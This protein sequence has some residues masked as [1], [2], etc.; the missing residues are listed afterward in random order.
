[1]GNFTSVLLHEHLQPLLTVSYFLPDLIF[2]I[3]S[4][5]EKVD[6]PNKEGGQ[7]TDST[8]KSD[9]PVVCLTLA[10]GSLAPYSLDIRTV[11]I[12]VTFFFFC[13]ASAFYHFWMLDSKPDSMFPKS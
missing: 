3:S 6:S 11:I 4:K 2:S 1:M 10:L 7:L 5:M 12:A 8:N 13:T 9:S